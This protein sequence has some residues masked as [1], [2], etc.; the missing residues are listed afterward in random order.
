MTREQKYGQYG[1]KKFTPQI[2]PFNHTLYQFVLSFDIMID[3]NMKFRYSLFTYDPEIDE[4]T[5]HFVTKFD[6][7]NSE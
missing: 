7:N 3:F 5:S 4:K 6:S 2:S 1:Q